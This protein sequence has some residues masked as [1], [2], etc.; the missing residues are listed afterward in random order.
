MDAV[1]LE[2]LPA[3]SLGVVMRYIFKALAI[4]H[5]GRVSASR[6]A[7]LINIEMLGPDRIRE[8][9]ED[10]ATQQ[11]QEAEPES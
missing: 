11:Q 3:T 1:G 5:I 6:D 10:R 9:L 7:M 2:L 4:K 8:L